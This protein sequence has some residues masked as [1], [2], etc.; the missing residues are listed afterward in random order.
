MAST[1]K[2]SLDDAGRLERRAAEDRDREADQQDH[3]AGGDQADDGEDPALA[4]GDLAEVDRR[5][6]SRARTRRIGS[7]PARQA[8]GR[9]EGTARPTVEQSTCRR[10]R[11][12]SVEV[13]R[14]HRHRLV[15]PGPP[16]PRAARRS[17]ARSRCRPDRP[18][19]GCGVTPWSAVP[20]SRP[21]SV[22]EGVGALD[23]I[24]VGELDGDVVEAHRVRHR[25]RRRVADAQQREVVMA[26]AGRG[27]EDHHVAHL[28]ATPGSR[29]GRDR[30]RAS[31]RGRAPSARRVRPPAAGAWTDATA[32]G[33][34]LGRS[35][36]GRPSLARQAGHGA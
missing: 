15:R 19:R 16:T 24:P 2:F 4:P 30:R 25:R 31:D 35:D 21:R 23:G 36:Q 9:T 6:P 3:P 5:S 27:Q 34:E 32:G 29:A 13:E 22:E 11:R 26:L 18:C 8:E 1:S 17:R 33:E 10:P 28:A 7:A 14:A 12:W 20:L